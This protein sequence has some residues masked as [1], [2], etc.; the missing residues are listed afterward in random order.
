MAS[1]SSDTESNSWYSDDSEWNYIPGPYA[2]ENP[3]KT[4]ENIGEAQS[5]SDRAQD[6]TGPYANEPI[7][8]E[9]WLVKYREKK[10]SYDERLKELQR[11]LDGEEELSTW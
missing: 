7:A 3:S 10:K 11:R 6:A 1:S 2:I 5:C 8:D 4:D 9:E